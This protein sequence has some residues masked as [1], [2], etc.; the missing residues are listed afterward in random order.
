MRKII[1]SFVT[2]FIAVFMISLNACDALDDLELIPSMKATVDGVEWNSLV[3][4][5][6]FNESASTQTIVITG[7]PTAED[8]ADETIVLTIFGNDV[9]TYKLG[10]DGAVVSDDCLVVYNKITDTGN[11][12]YTSTEAT[13][14][15]T[16]MD[17]EKKTISGTFSCTVCIVVGT[18][19]E[20]VNGTFKN[21]NYQ[22]Q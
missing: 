10:I 9:G 21:L 8:N 2:V 3:R 22:V 17:K 1:G 14:T 4:L 18:C 12:I 5:S 6:V 19:K 7:K 16:E 15:I 11:D 13:I 20:I